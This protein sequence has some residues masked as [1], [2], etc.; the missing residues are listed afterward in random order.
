MIPSHIV[1]GTIIDRVLL[2]GIDMSN[3]KEYPQFWNGNRKSDDAHLMI[4]NGEQIIDVLLNDIFVKKIDEYA[5]EDMS[6]QD[7]VDGYYILGN[8]AIVNTGSDVKQ[9]IVELNGL[10]ILEGP[11]LFLEQVKKT[12]KKIYS[13]NSEH[14]PWRLDV[15]MKIPEHLLYDIDAMCRLMNTKLGVCTYTEK[16]EREIHFT[17]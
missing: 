17:D 11:R 9:V 10:N 4:L 13:Q 14:V 5:L 1:L 8:T 3:T 7:A 16:I 12:K 2:D 6:Y 15:C